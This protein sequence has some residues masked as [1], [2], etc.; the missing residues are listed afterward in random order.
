[1]SLYYRGRGYEETGK[2]STLKVDAALLRVL[3]SLS[4]PVR[5]L[6]TLALLFMIL[7]AAF[8]L[9]RPYF[10]KIMID[11]HVVTRNQQ[12]I[13]QLFW[14]Y[15]GSI[16]ASLFLAYV[17]NLTLQTAG[18]RMIYVIRQ[19]VLRHQANQSLE[20]LE[21]QPVGR[22]V[23]RVTNDTEAV[24][25]LY[26]DVLVAFVSDLVM[27]AGIVIV[28]LMIQWKLALLSFS[29]LP[30]MILIAAAYQ[31]FAR[32]AYRN[33][34]EKTAALNSYIQERLDGIAAIKSFG[35][36]EPHYAGF[37]TANDAYL[38]AGLKEMRTFAA[39]RPM[40]DLLYTAAVILVIYFGNLESQYAGI[41]IGVIVAF[42]RYM[43]KFFWPIKDMAE[44]Y[45]LLQSAL[46]AAERLYPMLVE[47]PA[48]EVEV[49]KERYEPGRITFEGVWFAYEAERWV[50]RDVSFEVPS[51]K[52]YGIAGLSGSGKSTLIS[53]LLRF[54]QPH[55]GRILL[56]GKDIQELPLPQLRHRLAAVF[57]DVH[58]FRGSVAENISLFDPNSTDEQIIGAARQANIADYIESLPQKYDT[59]SGYLGARLSAGQRQLLSF[60]RALAT[61]ADILLLDEATSS[62]DSHTEAKVQ[63]AMQATARG[64]TMI[65]VAH[66]LS[67]ITEADCI[68]FM[69][70]GQIVERGTHE[71]LLNRGEKYARLYQ[72]Q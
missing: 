55:K 9:S 70:N 16:V 66:R 59:Q 22:M 61:D 32:L 56:D 45:N 10:M 43:E 2:K 44:K 5:P 6:L 13:E 29:I 14:L 36:F 54:Y 37:Q 57:Q 4:V 1:M 47:E 8:D 3:W 38:Q 18:Q 15:A 33:V 60:A 42:L 11:S 27:L 26:T 71:E 19:K 25:D 64:R 69:Y 67:T 46:A 40:I 23:T 21:D 30:L 49:K 51:G 39:F 24:K 48:G 17:E 65:V 72:S 68:L 12:G 31:K 28:M 41:E 20:Q 62:I 35:A 34:R 63:A 52:F 7:D 58:I 53:L 50:L